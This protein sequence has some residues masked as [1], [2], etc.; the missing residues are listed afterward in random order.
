M[1]GQINFGITQPEL[2]NALAAGYYGQEATRN[3]LQAQELQNQAAN[4]EI[5]NALAEQEA[6]K[7][8]IKEKYRFFSYGDVMLII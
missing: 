6:Y 1:A 7:Q 8:A 5:K 4:F 3:K 2:S